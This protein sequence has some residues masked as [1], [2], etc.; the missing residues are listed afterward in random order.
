[1]EASYD[2]NHPRNQKPHGHPIQFGRPDG[3]YA[4][5]LGPN[6]NAR[7]GM[8]EAGVIKSNIADR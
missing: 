1:V 5:L 7:D 6:C 3:P 8:H 2:E 4:V